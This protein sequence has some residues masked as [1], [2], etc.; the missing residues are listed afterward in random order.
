MSV[1]MSARL[2]FAIDRTVDR[3]VETAIEER[4]QPQHS[5]KPNRLVP[6]CQ[7]PKGRNAQGQDEKT[8]NP[9]TGSVG[10]ALDRVGAQI[11]RERPPDQQEKRDKAQQ[12]YEQP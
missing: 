1:P 6:A 8:Q 3:E 5:P 10:D 9:V 11:A 2:R 12:E 4:K 7:T